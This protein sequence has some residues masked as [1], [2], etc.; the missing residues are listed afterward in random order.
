MEHS[1]L[2]DEAEVIETDMSCVVCDKKLIVAYG[3]REDRGVCLNCGFPYK[4]DKNTNEIENFIDSIVYATYDVSADEIACIKQ[5]SSE[6]QKPAPLWSY[7][8][9]N[10]EAFEEFNRWA[11][12]NGFDEFRWD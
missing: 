8:P 10:Y 3:Y 1:N 2:R 4:M 6:K 7:S 9:F 5:Y 11:T 12:N